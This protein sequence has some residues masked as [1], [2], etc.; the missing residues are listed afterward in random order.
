VDDLVTLWAT[1]PENARRAAEHATQ[2]LAAV[3][4]AGVEYL[5]ILV[6]RV[7]AFPAEQ[8][9]LIA[10]LICSTLVVVLIL[11]VSTLRKLRKARRELIDAQARCETLQAQYDAEVKWRTAT[12]RVDAVRPP[13]SLPQAIQQPSGPVGGAPQGGASPKPKVAAPASPVRITTAPLMYHPGAATRAWGPTRA[14]P[15]KTH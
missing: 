5:N 14:D 8:L 12:E 2:A 4:S 11:W 10:A 9:R 1:L 3:W 7:Q 13:A 15:D 6:E